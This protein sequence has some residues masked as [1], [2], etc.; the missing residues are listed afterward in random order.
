MRLTRRDLR[1]QI[2]KELYGTSL[3]F[4]LEAEGD[5]TAPAAD[6]AAPAPDPAAAPPAPDPT[7]PAADPAAPAPDPAAPAVADPAAALP[8]GPPSLPGT[9]PPA[10][11][12]APGAPAGPGGTPV[13]GTKPVD[14]DDPIEKFLVKAEDQAIKKASGESQNES[15][16]R[17]NL[18]FLLEAEGGEPDLDMG[19]F[20]ADVARLI[21]N[22]MDLVDTKGNVIKKAQKYLKD[23]YPT[24]GQAYSD[25]LVNLLSRDYDINLKQKEEPA[26]SY[27]TGAKSSGGAAG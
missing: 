27:A 21:K 5:P 19:S 9:P 23:K 8:G 6:P 11:P 14:A 22:Y 16:R 26:D 17:R 18:S 12:G 15:L 24:K 2:I 20:A 4:L 13:Q 1:A 25:D 10:A 3:K 7:A